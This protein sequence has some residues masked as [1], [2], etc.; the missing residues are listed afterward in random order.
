[1]LRLIALLLLTTPAFAHSPVLDLAPK[2]RDAPLVLDEPEH[3]KGNRPV[4]TS[5]RIGL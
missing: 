3:S 5:C 4:G 1:M 2:T